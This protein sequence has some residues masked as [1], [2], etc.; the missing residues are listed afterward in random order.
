MTAE[1]TKYQSVR[2]FKIYL[3]RKSDPESKGKIEQ[4]VKFVK[5]NFS[6]NRIF[7]NLADWNNA[8]LA[9]LKRTGNYKI[10]HNTKKR[11]F[12]VHALEKQHL[13]NVSDTYLF[14]H[15]LTTSITRKIQKDNVIRY[16]ENR[17]SVPSG[18]H[19]YFAINITLVNSAMIAHLGHNIIYAKS[20]Q[21]AY[22][23]IRIRKLI[24]FI[25]NKFHL[26]VN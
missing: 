6:R 15:S 22:W 7:D 11:P 16:L 9:W 5:F 25:K 8:N 26:R 12:E 3:Y 19:F 21:Q 2:G 10:H 23:R 4:V 20:V 17:Y 13:Q 24:L 18:L 1:F 14:E